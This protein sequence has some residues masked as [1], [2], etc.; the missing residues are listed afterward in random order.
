MLHPRRNVLVSV[1]KNASRRWQLRIELIP[2][3][4][5]VVKGFRGVGLRALCG[6]APPGSRVLRIAVRRPAAALDPGASAG[7]GAGVDGQAGGLPVRGRAQ[8]D[9]ATFVGLTGR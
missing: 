3:G 4:S 1:T 6:P 7:P 9:P 5:C 8:P 2:Y